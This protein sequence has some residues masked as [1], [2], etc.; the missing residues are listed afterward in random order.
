MFTLHS[1][2]W[3]DDERMG[4]MPTY[5][6]S[7]PVDA[8]PGAQCKIMQFD[9]SALVTVDTVSESREATI[10]PKAAEKAA[11]RATEERRLPRVQAKYPDA[12]RL[13]KPKEAAVQGFE[14]AVFVSKKVHCTVYCRS[15]TLFVFTVLSA[16]HI[17]YNQTLR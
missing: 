10:A 15:L 17:H 12:S 14:L 7:G 11:L 4:R 3:A 1:R 16:I 5:M 2:D 8:I 9:L 13:A 6:L